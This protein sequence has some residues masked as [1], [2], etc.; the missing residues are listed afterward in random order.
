MEESTFS[1]PK[2]IENLEMLTKK[3]S[4]FN[5]YMSNNGWLIEIEIKKE[6]KDGKWDDIEKAYRTF[7]VDLKSAT[8]YVSDTLEPY[9]KR[10]KE[11]FTKSITSESGTNKVPAR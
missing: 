8:T 9:I 6:A 2:I 7:T 3:I 1:Y 4:E 5:T 11:L 10:K